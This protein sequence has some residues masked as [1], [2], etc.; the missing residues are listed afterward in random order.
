MPHDKLPW[1]FKPVEWLNGT[2]RFLGKLC[3]WHRKAKQK[4]WEKRAREEEHKRKKAGG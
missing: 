1:I 2:V 4:D 3:P